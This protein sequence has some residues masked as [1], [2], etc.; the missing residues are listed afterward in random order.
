LQ[1]QQLY[2]R[3]AV[4]AEIVVI[5]AGKEG[6]QQSN[7]ALVPNILLMDGTFGRHGRD[8]KFICNFG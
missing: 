8:E 5:C 6:C 3:T 7:I 4:G 1:Q 2:A